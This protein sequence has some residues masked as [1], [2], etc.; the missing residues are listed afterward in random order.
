M[1]GYASRSMVTLHLVF[2]RGGFYVAVMF[3]VAALY[4]FARFDDPAALKA[5]LAS[6]CENGGVKGTV[7]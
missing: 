5:S 1:S 4:H 6:V 3:T 7:L 2:A